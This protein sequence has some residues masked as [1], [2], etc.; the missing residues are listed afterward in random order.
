MVDQQLVDMEGECHRA[1]A[2][3]LRVRDSFNVDGDVV[4]FEF[5][6]AIFTLLRFEGVQ[7]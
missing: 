1:E 5:S 7:R 6:T 4:L 2:L 3:E